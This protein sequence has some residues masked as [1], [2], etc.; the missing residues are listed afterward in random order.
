M[1]PIRASWRWLDQ[2]SR[3]VTAL[4]SLATFLL[5]LVGLIA[6]YLQLDE[7]KRL[8][9][10]YEQEN[11]VDLVFVIDNIGHQQHLLWANTGKVPIFIHGWRLEVPANPQR[12]P[13]LSEAVYK[14]LK[15]AESDSQDITGEIHRL[16]SQ[17]LGVPLSANNMLAQPIQAEFA[18]HTRYFAR[19]QR[20]ERRVLFRFNWKPPDQS[21]VEQ[22]APADDRTVPSVH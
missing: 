21:Q 9:A 20:R 4:G 3:Q 17:N 15:P 19:G 2:N 5:F 6:L 16:F 8:Q 22:I 13:N 14:G 12:Q 1:S 10:Q 11:F 18:V 7:L